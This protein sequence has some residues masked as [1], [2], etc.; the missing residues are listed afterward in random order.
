MLQN[1]RKNGLEVCGLLWG[2][3][4]FLLIFIQFY[5]FDQNEWFKKNPNFPQNFPLSKM[6]R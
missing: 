6:I 3:K 4:Q 5:W 2:E 1:N